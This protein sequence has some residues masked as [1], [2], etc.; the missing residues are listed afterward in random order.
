MQTA[1][2]NHVYSCLEKTFTCP[3]V[4]KSQFYKLVGKEISNSKKIW[5][6]SL[7]PI[8]SHR[9]K[10]W[11]FIYPSSLQTWDLKTRVIALF[12]FW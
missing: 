8:G 2:H 9:K 12:S 6:L 1:D 5:N 3:A 10:G 11:H 7:A 4:F